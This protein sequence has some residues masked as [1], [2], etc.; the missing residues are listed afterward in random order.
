MTHAIL[1][2]ALRSIQ[3]ISMTACPF[4]FILGFMRSHEESELPLSVL[5][6]SV[7]DMVALRIRA[8][9]PSNPPPELLYQS[10]PAAAMSLM[11][12]LPCGTAAVSIG[13]QDG[14]YPILRN[15]RAGSDGFVIVYA[16]K[17]NNRYEAV[18]ALY[19][20][21]SFGIAQ[22]YEI[23]CRH[24]K[25][26]EGELARI[27]DRY[28][29]LAPTREQW[30]MIL[31]DGGYIA[32]STARIRAE[33]T[34]GLFEN[35]QNATFSGIL[36]RVPLQTGTRSLT[37]A[38]IPVFARA[39]LTAEPNPGGPWVPFVEY[40]RMRALQSRPPEPILT[41]F[42]QWLKT[43]TNACGFTSWTLRR[44]MFFGD[45]SEWWGQKNR[46]RTLHEG[47]DFVEGLRSDTGAAGSPEGA[48][49]CGMADGE[50]VAVFDDFLNKTVVVRHP[51]IRNESGA[52]LYTLYSHIRPAV[53]KLGPVRQ[54]Q[55]L[56]HVE[57]ATSA[58]APAHLH[59]TGA[60]IPESIAAGEIS[61]DQIHPGFAPVV[62]INFNS[63]VNAL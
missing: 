62:L 25:N 14:A 24:V 1:R 16:R 59:L 26:E 41:P 38:P 37:G 6:I 23:A 19:R 44:G 58:G 43:F 42:R 57:K 22:F 39:E 32:L 5:R 17:P 11:A 3:G 33:L 63:L 48:P 20:N 60:W 30:E 8:P 2:A 29:Y 55:I 47:I 34:P 61:M 15:P 18:E 27:P 49:V 45:H 53:R 46:R 36:A 10:F 35:R 28:A 51:A 7:A 12:T 31:R 50:L 4:P 56:G 54:G 40:Q 13:E 52:Y 9:E 21:Q